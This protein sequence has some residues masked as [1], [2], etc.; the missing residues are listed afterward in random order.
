MYLQ[1]GDIKDH[2]SLGDK[3]IYVF[4]YAICMKTKLS[5]KWDYLFQRK[6]LI[7]EYIPRILETSLKH[8]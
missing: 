3:C 8:G 6:T 5:I 2:N 7:C 1:E 4:T